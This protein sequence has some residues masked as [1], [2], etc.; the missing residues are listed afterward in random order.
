VERWSGGLLIAIGF[1]FAYWGIRMLNDRDGVAGGP[2]EWVLWFGACTIFVSAGI[3]S[4]AVHH[5][6]Y[7]AS[8]AVHDELSQTIGEDDHLR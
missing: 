6:K 4:I 8:R 1:A 7:R 2:L 5:R 3:Y